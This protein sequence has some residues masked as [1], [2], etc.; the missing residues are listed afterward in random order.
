MCRVLEFGASL[1]P[2][3]LLPVPGAC[4]PWPW[5]RWAVPLGPDPFVPSPLALSGEG[6]SLASRSLLLGVG[7]GP[8]PPPCAHVA[9]R[10]QSVHMVRAGRWLT[11][12]CLFLLQ[13][14]R[15]CLKPPPSPLFLCDVG[16]WIQA[17]PNRMWFWATPGSHRPLSQLRGTG[18]PPNSGAPWGPGGSP[19]SEERWVLG[20]RDPSVGLE[21]KRPGQL[22]L[23]FSPLEQP[24]LQAEP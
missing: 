2:A 12:Q 11:S 23:E 21:S 10:W 18:P 9:W 15:P 14:S 5:C 20:L 7:A 13:A 19:P 17:G 4:W 16:M 8:A 3:A 1:P 24:C 6:V 22:T